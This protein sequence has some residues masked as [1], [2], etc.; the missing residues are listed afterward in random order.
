M[1]WKI[2]S[3]CELREK[4]VIIVT[5]ELEVHRYQ[6]WLSRVHVVLY[7]RRIICSPSLYLVIG[8]VPDFMDVPL[9]LSPH[10]AIDPAWKMSRQT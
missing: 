4:M 8:E 3:I 6:E 1:S 2:R 7:R 5:I 10:V 9:A